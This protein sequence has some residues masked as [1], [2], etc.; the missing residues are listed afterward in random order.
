MKVACRHHSAWGRIEAVGALCGGERNGAKGWVRSL[1]G[2][3]DG[4][5]QGRGTHYTS[6]A[7]RCWQG[8]QRHCDAWQWDVLDRGNGD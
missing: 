5:A 1:I 2:V 4:G 7:A 6:G 8:R 3:E